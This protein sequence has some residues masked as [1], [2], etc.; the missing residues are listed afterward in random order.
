ME[1]THNL[2]V[3]VKNLYFVLERPANP[4]WVLNPKQNKDWY[5]LSYV[6]SGSVQYRFGGETVC[7]KKGNVVFIKTDQLYSAKSD[8]EDPWHFF[9]VAFSLEYMDEDSKKLLHSLPN[10]F[11][12]SDSSRMAEN[13]AEL[14][15][16]WSAKGPGYLMKGRSLILDILYILL[17]DE[18]RRQK[19]S[20]HYAKIARVVD[21]MRANCERSYSLAELCAMTGLSPSY[22]RQLFKEMTGMSAIQF[23]NQQK[24]QRA[25]DLILSQNCNVTEAAQAVG[26]SDIYYFSRM[27]RKLTGQ[28][29]SEYLHSVR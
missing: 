11:T 1:P 6:V 23:Q 15:R 29:P 28:N 21:M 8:P 2:D 9:S 7:A 25:K 13:F 20:T 26:F 4:R 18:S 3:Q 5:A 10:V 12:S 17:S 19:A 14:H 24:I 22:F 16:I 27:F